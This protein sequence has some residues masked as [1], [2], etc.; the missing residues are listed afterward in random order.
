MKGIAVFD[1]DGTISSKDSFLEFIKFSRGRLLLYRCILINGPFI[2]LFYLK[3][4]SN[5][6]LK[7]KFFSYCFKGISSKEIYEKGR[8]FSRDIIPK[9]CYNDALKIIDWHKRQGHEIFILTASSEIWLGEWC[10]KNG[11]E[12]ICTNFEFRKGKF[13]GK[14]N[15]KNCHGVEKYIRIEKLLKNYNFEESY[16]Y[17]DSDSDLHFISL[18]KYRFKMALTESNVKNRWGMQFQSF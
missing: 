18:V 12:L 6:K 17:G 10:R 14:I 11:L 2:L 7:E 13:T 5:Q 4:Y 8:L 16:A 1:F 3:L 9:I 15:G